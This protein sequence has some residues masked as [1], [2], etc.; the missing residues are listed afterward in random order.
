MQNESQ[1][2]QAAPVTSG[3]AT[4]LADHDHVAG[5][6]AVA[7]KLR[8][9]HA[10]ISEC[11]ERMSRWSDDGAQFPGELEDTVESIGGFLDGAIATVD[12]MV[13]AKWEPPKHKQPALAV[14]DKVTCREDCLSRYTDVYAIAMEMNGKPGEVLTAKTVFT[15]GKVIGEGRARRFATSIGLVPQAHIKRVAAE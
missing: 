2:Q 14:G 10:L 1:N 15:I 12:G 11:H 4:G 8:R 7:A 5:I 13:A 3:G 6:A 9:A